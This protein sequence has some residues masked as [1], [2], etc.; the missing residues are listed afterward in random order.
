MNGNITLEAG[1]QWQSATKV[2]PVGDELHFFYIYLNSNRTKYLAQLCASAQF[3]KI[4]AQYLLEF[5]CLFTYTYLMI[6][7]PTGRREAVNCQYKIYSQAEN[8]HF[9]PAVATRCTDSRETWH[10]QCAVRS[11]E[12]CFDQVLCRFWFCFH[13]FFSD[14]LD[15]SCFGR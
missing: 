15:S 2:I 6:C 10:G 4:H 9:R 13:R 8:Q 7:L 11:R 5:P 14:A 1:W 3:Q 12:T